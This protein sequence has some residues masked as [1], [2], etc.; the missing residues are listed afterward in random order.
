MV[1]IF[2]G[3]TTFSS[4]SL[5]TPSLAL[6]GSWLPAMGN[7]VLSVTLCLLAVTNGHLAAGWIGLLESEASPRA[8]SSTP[9]RW[10]PAA[11]GVHPGGQN[12]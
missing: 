10:S 8:R 11:E 12:A 6:D 1:G 4:F 7:V 9:Q 3:F 5:Q 2:G